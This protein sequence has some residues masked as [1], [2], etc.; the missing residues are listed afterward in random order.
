M[1]HD[2]V[3]K[4]MPIPKGGL[5]LFA[6][7]V[8][9]IFIYF[10]SFHLLNPLDV[11]NE[12]V[13]AVSLGM[14]LVMCI[15]YSLLITNNHVDVWFRQYWYRNIKGRKMLVW[16][17]EK[18][19]IKVS[20]YDEI[21]DYQHV[22]NNRIKESPIAIV[23]ILGGWR[24]HPIKIIINNNEM[25]G[26]GQYWKFKKSRSLPGYVKVIDSLSNKI[27]L[28][29]ERLL[30]MLINAKHSQD[31]NSWDTQIYYKLKKLREVL[32]ILDESKL[33]RIKAIDVII[34]VETLIQDTS[35]FVH[36]KEGQKIRE[37]IED[38]LIELLPEND[39]TR[40]NL[41]RKK[42]AREQAA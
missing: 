21:F 41:L 15:C 24:R 23:I 8:V 7:P 14:A 18:Q 27:T 16:V 3:E 42:A 38:Q 2:P 35:R 39:S 22:F 34:N 6:L 13:I 37:Y 25:K 5:K 17:N 9:G 20:Y 19:E 28:P 4:H 33:A 1:S 11:R 26:W 12:L 36:S 29:A 30:E 40:K 32:A 31:F 10:G